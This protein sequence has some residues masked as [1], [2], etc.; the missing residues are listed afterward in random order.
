MQRA[1]LILG[2]YG[3]LVVLGGVI[4][5]IFSSSTISLIMGSICGFLVL[6]SAVAM[7]KNKKVGLW[8]AL[9]LLLIL[10]AFFTY[11]FTSHPQF[12]P[13]G[14]FCLL[15]ILTLVVLILRLRNYSKSM[16]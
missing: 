14:L 7:Y 3:I 9:S 11:K 8:C 5:F 4:G 13:S 15:S 16:S 12:F 1:A 10:D 6:L 2:L